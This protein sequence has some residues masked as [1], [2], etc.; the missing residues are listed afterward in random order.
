MRKSLTVELRVGESV[1]IDGG[2]IIATLEHKSGQRARLAF[3]AEEQTRIERVTDK[4]NIRA[5][6]GLGVAAGSRARPR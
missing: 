3:E 4:R 5:E 6:I 1:A 2:R